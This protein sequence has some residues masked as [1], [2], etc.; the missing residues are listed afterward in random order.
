MAVSPFDDRILAGLLG[1]GELAALFDECR[2]VARYNAVEA[3]L[4]DAM[5]AESLIAATD[6]AAIRRVTREFAPDLAALG[7]GTAVDGLPIP[8]YVTALR[9]ALPE[10]ARAAVHRHST[11][12]DIMD[13]ALALALR[14]ANG[15]LAARLAALDA[16]LATL[17]GRF[18]GRPLMARTR[19]QAALPVTAAH[20]IGLWRAP[21]PGHL[22]AL[23][24]LRPRI[25]ALQFGGPVGTRE[26]WEGRGNDVAARMAE[27]LGLAEPGR[28]THT[29]RSAVAGYAALLAAMAASAGKIGADVALMAQQGIDEVRLA[30]GGTSSA[31]PHKANPI[32]AEVL[33]AL[34]RY[35]AI[36]AGGVLQSAVHEQERSGAAWTLEMMLLP[37]L[38]V[39]AG[40]SLSA[41]AE[42]VGRIEA[43]GTAARES[44]GA[45]PGDG[46]ASPQN[47]RATGG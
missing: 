20:R 5:A 44:G 25:E 22:D 27:A 33:V 45:A 31:M 21:L 17:A 46:L 3:A 13:T 14:G 7:A 12:Q 11:S 30:G 41:A 10:P 16:E 43:I 39:A 29:D 34:A 47:T 18:G 4:A 37:S 38:V 19:R 2:T 8:A 32:L 24:A 6:A 28:A 26:G 40:R 42:L 36:L 1:D 15:I 35:T 23:G 9:A